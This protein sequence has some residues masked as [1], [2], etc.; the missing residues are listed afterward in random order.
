MSIFK[1]EEKIFPEHLVDLRKSGLSDEM[2]NIAGI[3]SVP[4]NELFSLF[5]RPGL[6]SAYE[7]PYHGL[8]F[9]RFKCFYKEKKEGQPKYLQG[10]GTGSHLY[11]PK[12]VKVFLDDPYIPLFICEGEKKTLKACQEGLIC[13]GLTGLWNWSDG[14]KNLIPDFDLINFKKRIVYIVPDNDYRKPNKHG[15]Y[16]KNLVDAVEVL[17]ELLRKRKARVTVVNLPEDSPEKGLDDFLLA[18]DVGKFLSM[19]NHNFYAKEVKV[20]SK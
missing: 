2:L 8:S 4:A 3:R 1:T 5:Y 16:N 10:Y 20:L 11:I 9:S 18:Y 17:A 6:T 19:I 15:Y 7:I 12:I 14:K 13:I